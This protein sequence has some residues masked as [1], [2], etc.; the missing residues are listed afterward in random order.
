MEKNVKENNQK[1]KRKT[2]FI[3]TPI[4]DDNTEIRRHI[5]GIIGQAIEPAIGGEF[6]IRVAHREFEIGSINDRVIKNVYNAD[7]VIA[8]LTTLNPNV[9]FE[10]AMRYSYGKPAIV[11]A[12]KNTKLP[13]DMIE[14]NT[15][16]YVNDPTGAAELKNNIKKFVNKIDFSANDY[17]PIIATLKTAAAFEN[18]EKDIKDP[19]SKQIFSLL[20][21][22]IDDIEA[23][24]KRQDNR[25]DVWNLNTN[26]NLNFYDPNNNVNGKEIQSYYEKKMSE[27]GERA[28]K[29]IKELQDSNGTIYVV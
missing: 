2:C 22:K 14:E 25:K 7:L 12:E 17:G 5:D 4:G 15:L 10:L 13:F 8:N 16:F 19:E 11:I 18:A 28:E 24:L 9:M 1:I 21:K 3:V 20:L 26:S 6:D 27:I 29:K 23:E